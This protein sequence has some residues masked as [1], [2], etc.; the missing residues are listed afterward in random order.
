VTVA[1][2]K[3][4]DYPGGNLLRDGEYRVYW[5][6]GIPTLGVPAHPSNADLLAFGTT[7]IARTEPTSPAF[8]LATT[9][10]ELRA[11]GLPNAPGHTMLEQTKTARAAGSEYLSYEFGW[12]PLV[13]GLRDFS[14]TVNESDKILRSYQ[15]RANKPI[16]R[17]YEWP[18]IQ[19]QVITPYK[20]VNVIPF[21][22]FAEGSMTETTL[23]RK[24][25]E[26]SYIYYLPVSQSNIDKFR[27]YGSDARKLYGI[28]LNPEVLWNL[29]P[30]SWAADWFANTGDVMH[31]VSA[32]GQDGMV[33]RYAHIMCH[34]QRKVAFTGAFD[35]QPCSITVTDE[36]KSRLPATPYGFGL[37]WDGFSPK[38]LAII[39]ALG[40]S[41]SR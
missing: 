38:Q 36:V 18:D 32:I 40:L 41:R 16:K 22:G 20:R 1:T 21:D 37:N 33:I 6:E 8:D 34:T 19:D 25:F 7:A 30:W 9:I 26:A 14:K 31:N 39:S 23:I 17:R 27:R 24:W 11:E 28:D 5:T 4:Y 13:R 35:G 15:E 29:S 3:S 2:V 10:G 12:A